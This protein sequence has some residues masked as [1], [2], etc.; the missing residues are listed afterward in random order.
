VASGQDDRRR[1]SGPLTE[2]LKRWQAASDERKDGRHRKR[3]VRRRFN[4]SHLL[5]SHEKN[6]AIAADLALRYMGVR[7]RGLSRSRNRSAN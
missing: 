6:A 2:P 7:S 4:V 5:N 1:E 3:F